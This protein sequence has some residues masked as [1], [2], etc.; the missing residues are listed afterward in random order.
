MIN[1]YARRFVCIL[2]ALLVLA[3]LLFA[4]EEN[5]DSKTK[6]SR[7]SLLIIARSI[8]D[9]ARCH[10]LVTVDENGKPHAREMDPFAPEE[11]MTIW[12]GTNP[13][14][15]KVKQIQKNPNVVMFYYDTKG[16]SYVALEGKA[17]IVNDPAQ[18]AKY[19]KEY[20]KGYYPDRD[21]DYVLIQI[22]PDI[23]ELISYKHNILGTTDSFLPP[24]VKFD[25]SKDK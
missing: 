11:N 5:R 23:M 15:R 24:S 14:T 7:D 8:I 22:V 18:K 9:S 10:V 13:K 25:N 20:W 16:I 1:V 17:R 19:W 21:K 6:V 2:S 12:L 3:S 4:Q